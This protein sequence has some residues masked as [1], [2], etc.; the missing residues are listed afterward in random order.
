MN[1][2]G[3]RVY[4]FEGIEVDVA[5]GCLKRDGAELHL[6][7]KTFHVLLYL[8]E[9][10]QR[11]VTKDELI[12]R[13][14]E[15]TAVGD[16]AL[17]KCIVDIRKALG[18]NPRHPRFIKTISK[19]GY[20]FI[21]AVEEQRLCAPA[22]LETKEVTTVELEYEEEFDDDKRQL[23]LPSRVRASRRPLAIL[24]T[25]LAAI[26]VA[27]VAIAIYLR[28]VRG[29]LPETT[30]RQVAGKKTVAV[31][32]FENLS[33]SRDLDWLREGLAD[34][35]ITDLSRSRSATVLSR[36]QLH[37]LL[38]RAGYSQA[39]RVRLDEALDIARRSQAE[40]LVLGT[41]SR[42]DKEIRI[43][44]HLHDGRDG[45]LLAAESTIVDNPAQLLMQVDLLSLKLAAHLGE[46]SAGQDGKTGLAAVMTNN[47]EAYR[48]Y[49]LALEKAPA[50]DNLEAISLLEKATALDPRFAMA[51]ARI[52]YAYAVTWDH[53]A[54][55]KP[56]L[57]KA[58]QLSDRLTEK[59]KLYITAWYAIANLD[60]EGAMR[61][62]REIIDQ[63]PLE[64][65]AYWRL[66]CLLEGEDS[67][68]EAITV[69]KQALTIDPENK[70][71]YNV[72]GFLYAD[73]GRHTEAVAMIER[74]VA[75]APAEPNAHNSLGLIYDWAGRYDEAIAAFN[76]SLALDPKFDLATVHL[77]NVYFRQGRYQAAIDQYRR[78]IQVAP[79]DWERAR[80]YD[81]IAW[82]YWKKGDL[83][84]AEAAARQQVAYE[85][86]SVFNSV[87]LALE[88]GDTTRAER[89]MRQS[90]SFNYTSRG[91]RVSQRYVKFIRAYLALRS[92][93]LD[94]AL[95]LFNQ[96]LKHRPP[97]WA[98]DTYEDCLANAL[99]E[100][101]RFDEA[102]GEYNR[103]LT[104]NPNYPLAHYHLAQAYEKKGE[105]DKARAEYERFL[106]TWNAADPDIPQLIDARLRVMALS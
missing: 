29:P 45:H 66:G 36:Q 24:L 88:R 67:F 82:V 81:R 74:Q 98:I 11:L 4:R 99:L 85:K 102:I 31:M 51:Y 46:A 47:L 7:Q 54:K 104:I 84:R 64:I 87:L 86:T 52:G 56:Y 71:I 60:F 106:Q 89:L 77:A 72:L 15:G 43:D 62:L 12:E 96:T 28:P 105:A 35:L 100:L 94:E 19:S 50:L 44:A 65:E 90:D 6:R 14:W 16:D 63:H 38:E 55:A 78:Y 21:G 3:E 79:S 32:H 103:V 13:L 58:F 20:R 17:V 95:D 40:A 48:Y 22:T 41:F 92:G 76:R 9:Q 73:L 101:G 2:L 27:V 30:L 39:A 34:M 61:P 10:R 57:E 80:G 59:D 69:L 53:A 5:Q 68:E 18:D 26:L 93:K 33:G 75:L 83:K 37:L 8:L 97:I 91:A 70:D 1:Q 42:I 25:A 23:A 49:S